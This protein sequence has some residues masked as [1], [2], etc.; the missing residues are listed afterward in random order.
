MQ[1]GITPVIAVILLLLVTISITGF[2]FMFFG[3]TAETAGGQVETELEKQTSAIGENFVVESVDSSKVYIRNLGTQ[4]LNNLNFYVNGVKIDS[5]GTVPAG[6]AGAMTLNDA[7]LAQLPNDAKLKVTSLGI[8]REEN[9]KFYKEEVVGYWKFDEADRDK[10]TDYSGN[11]NDGTFYGETWNDGDLKPNCPNCP[12]QIAGKYG[13]ALSFDGTDDYVDLKTPSSLNI[14]GDQITISAWV[15]PGS[16]AM[17][18]GAFARIV[19]KPNQYELIVQDDNKVMCWLFSAQG[20]AQLVT[21]NVPTGA[22]THIS[23]VLE[24]GAIKLYING[25]IQPDVIS[26]A[27]NLAGTSN[28]A[29]I[30]RSGPQG[31]FSGIIDEVRIYSRALTPQEVAEDMDSAYPIDRTVASYSFEKIESNQVQ[32][33][34]NIAKGKYGAAMSFD[35]VDDIVR[36]G[37]P[38]SL[39]MTDAITVEAWT[40]PGPLNQGSGYRNAAAHYISWTNNAAWIL[41][42]SDAGNGAFTPHVSVANGGHNAGCP[43]LPIDGWSHLVLT[44]DGETLRGYVNDV[45]CSNTAPSGNL[46]DASGDVTI[47][48]ANGFEYFSGTVDEVRIMNVARPMG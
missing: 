29:Y 25:G 46:V 26:L 37:D 40:K 21:G 6:Q 3:R 2:A 38:P 32:D 20:D 12:S 14:A 36:L 19:S 4:E 11:G 43:V 27:G 48:A 42:T 35:G 41:R 39:S 1:K 13:N 45:G 16:V 7:Q 15:K 5:S 18:G 22:W 23:C 30:G 17:T 33:T 28:P 34:H 24:G 47:G 10:V 44:Y 9:V 31:Y 8:S